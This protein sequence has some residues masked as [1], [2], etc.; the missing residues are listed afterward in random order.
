[1]KKEPLRSFQS[2]FHKPNTGNGVL[3]LEQGQLQE[4]EVLRELFADHI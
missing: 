2:I 1:M 3:Q 4:R